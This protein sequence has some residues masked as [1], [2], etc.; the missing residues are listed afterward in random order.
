MPE[1]NK[2][3]HSKWEIGLIALVVIY[4]ISFVFYSLLWIFGPQLEECKQWILGVKYSRESPEYALSCLFFAGAIGGAFYCLRSI[5]QRL[6]DAYT[7][8]ARYSRVPA[9]TDPKT[10]FNIKVWFFWYF[11]RPI[12]SGV[13]A[14]VVIC[15]F[16]QGLI[17]FGSASAEKSGTI[18]FQ[19]GLGFLIGFGTH[20]VLDKIEE[21][22]GVL[23]AKKAG[24]NNT[25]NL[26]ANE[27]AGNATINAKEA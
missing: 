5:Y 26:S 25:S 17:N 23:F 10:V 15:L 22:I 9:G 16:N 21:V 3:L 20:Q 12:Q 19:I 14:I 8:N 27:G 24:S 6:S 18:Y 2:V 7:P 4:E 1:E 13:L 11:Y